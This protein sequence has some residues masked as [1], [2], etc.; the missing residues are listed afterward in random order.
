MALEGMAAGCAVIGTRV[1]GLPEAI[2]GGGMVVEPGAPAVLA[3]AISNFI[4]DPR[5]M[6]SLRTLGRQRIQSQSPTAVA[7]RYLQAVLGS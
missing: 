5:L 4:D 2:G 6:N 7:A 3:K 1:G